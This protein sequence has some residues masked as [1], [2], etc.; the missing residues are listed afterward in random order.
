MK[1]VTLLVCGLLLAAG[2]NRPEGDPQRG[3]QLFESR[4]IACHS[5]E[6]HRVG[7]AL[8]GVYGREA[9]TAVGFAYSPALRD[10]THRWSADTLDRWLAGPEAFLPGQRMSFTVS[11][12]TDRA[13]LIAWLATLDDTNPSP[14]GARP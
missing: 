11:G 9:G 8:R 1:Y 4:C 2:S 6:T 14:S 10:A 13:D 3:R 7:P 5:L 12:K